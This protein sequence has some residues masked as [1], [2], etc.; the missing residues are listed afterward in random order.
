MKITHLQS[1]SQIISLGNINVL[2]DPWLTEGEYYGSWYHY[3]PFEEC[4][5][6]KLSY[7]YI[8][9]SHIHPDHLSE[10]TFRKLPYK[11]PVLIHN[12]DSKFV[13]R[14]LEMLGYQ[15]IECSHGK[16]FFLENGGSITIYAAD[17]CNPELCFKF[18]GCGI[19]EKKFASTQ[20]DTLA[21]FDF[22]EK[23]IINTNDCPFELAEIT[24]K[25]NLLDTKNVDLLLVGYGGAG[26][27]PQCFEFE[28]LQEKLC[29]AK[30]KQIHFLDLAVKFIKLIKPISYAPFAGTY[31]LGSKFSNLTKYRGVPSLNE[32]LLYLQEKLPNI[33]KGLLLEKFDSY[34]VESNILTKHTKKFNK[35]LAEYTEEIK[36]HSLAYDK[37]NWNDDELTE[38][39]QRSYKR[40]KTKAQE[41][42]FSS[43]T[44]LVIKSDKFAFQLGTNSEPEEVDKNYEA[45]EPFVK[46]TVAHNLLHRLLRG[47]RYAHWNNAEIGSHLHYVRRPNNFER[48]LYH[49]MC[50][51]HQ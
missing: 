15:V 8:Y 18:L 32:A 19:A 21:V 24:I 51:L 38:L 42:G 13:K 1:S 3:P 47:P 17:N 16:P 45:T 2:T 31:I 7:D 10:E 43:N 30:E 49:C 25:E 35:T 11:K 22:E 6:S 12:Y 4:N 37:D 33:S 44:R 20:I 26:P 29:A 27:Y 5:I 14:K 46:I 48:A 40:F 34:D 41:I 39:L 23:R 36:K 28:N 50:F 9:V